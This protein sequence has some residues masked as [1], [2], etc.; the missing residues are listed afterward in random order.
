MLDKIKQF[1]N[2]K[3]DTPEDY[4]YPISHECISGHESMKW[5]LQVRDKGVVAICS[6]CALVFGLTELID[7]IMEED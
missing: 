2:I 5:L 6:D 3:K 1:P 4:V 7:E